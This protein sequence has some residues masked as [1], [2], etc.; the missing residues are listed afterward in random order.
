MMPY[1]RTVPTAPYRRHPRGIL[2]R[3]RSTIPPAR[4]HQE[5]GSGGG[6]LRQPDHPRFHLAA[7]VPA[8]TPAASIPQI[9]DSAYEQ[10]R[11]AFVLSTADLSLIP[12]PPRHQTTWA[13][14]G[15]PGSSSTSSSPQP[16]LLLAVDQT[17]RDDHGYSSNDDFLVSFTLEKGV[18]PVVN[19]WGSV[20][21]ERT[22]FMST[23]QTTGLQR[24]LF[25][26]NTLVSARSTT[27]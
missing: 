21:Y 11:A 5:L 25:D 16:R 6:V 13:S 23:I 27:R 9:Y 7:G 19:I 17:P 1:F 18:I 12:T 2:P 10:N 4:A 26:A 24:G 8:T 14:T 22:N 15:R 3:R 20:S